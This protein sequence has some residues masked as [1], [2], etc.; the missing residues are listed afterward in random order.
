MLVL[1]KYHIYTY[2]CPFF[3]AHL[4]ALAPLPET[5]DGVGTIRPL[6]SRCRRFGRNP[7]GVSRMACLLNFFGLGHTYGKSGKSPGFRN[8]PGGGVSASPRG[9]GFRTPP[10]I[11]FP[12]SPGDWV[13]ASP[14]DWFSASPI[15]V[16]ARKIWM[17]TGFFCSYRVHVHFPIF[18]QSTR[19]RSCRPE[20]VQPPSSSSLQLYARVAAVVVADCFEMSVPF[21]THHI[22]YFCRAS[23]ACACP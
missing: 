5:P 12:H 16:Y 14:G 17:Q 15:P 13:Y 21:V 1:I 6:G 2:K 7:W 22:P 9:L 23:T 11:G 10:G 20:A 4:F 18:V 3:R 8:I 19:L